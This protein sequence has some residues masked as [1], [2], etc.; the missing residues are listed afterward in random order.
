MFVFFFIQN[1]LHSYH[2][3]F[4][5]VIW[6]ELDQRFLFVVVFVS[7]FSL[8]CRYLSV[9]PKDTAHGCS[10]RVDTCHGSLF[11]AGKGFHLE[12][13]LQFKK[14][15]ELLVFIILHSCFITQQT[16]HERYLGKWTTYSFSKYRFFYICYGNLLARLLSCF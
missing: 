16:L 3:R 7:C 2:W 15:G 12:F 10:M 8:I 9:P 13:L 14:L 5:W 6:I 11:L 4:L 1:I